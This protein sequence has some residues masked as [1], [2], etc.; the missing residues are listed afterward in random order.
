MAL[1]EGRARMV[2]SGVV[3]YMAEEQGSMKLCLK[4]GEELAEALWI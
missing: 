1:W 4:M 3:L 2:K